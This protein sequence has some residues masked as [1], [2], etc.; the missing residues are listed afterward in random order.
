MKKIIT[1]VCA[2][3]LMLYLSS[4][5]TYAQGRNSGGSA[6]DAHAPDVSHG[7]SDDHNQLHHD[8]DK[9]HA[10]KDSKNFEDRI[11]QNSALKTRLQGMLPPGT[12]LK[13]AASGFKNQGQFIAALHVSKNLNI[14]FADLKAKMTGAN[15][16]SLG[17]AI[18]NLK[19][20]MPEKDADKEAD[21]AEKEAKLTEKVK[22]IS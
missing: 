21:K 14:P 10:A 20:N 6:R 15:S 1:I 7:K 11:E 4:L 8:D 22:A 9:S 19:P 16:E 13:T 3:G 5:T 2:L 12:D 18:H 17:E